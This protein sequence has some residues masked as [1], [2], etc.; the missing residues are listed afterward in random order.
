MSSLLSD[1]F[2]K[3]AKVILGE[4]GWR[5]AESDFKDK[6]IDS[7]DAPAGH[8]PFLA[9]PDTPET[10][11]KFITLCAQHKIAIVPQGGNTGRVHGGTPYG[12][13]LLSSDRLKTI[14]KLD[15]DNQSLIV[16]AGVSLQEVQEIADEAGL[17]FPLSLASEGTAQIGG[18]AATNAGGINV[19]QYGMMRDLVL[20]IE[21]V[22]PDGRIWDGLTTLRK[23]NTGYDLKQL[24][25]GS[26][27]TLGFI[28]AVSLKL[29]Q[30][31]K[32]L[33]SGY[34]PLPS[35][36]AALKLLNHLKASLGDSI[37]AFELMPQSGIELVLKYIPDTRDPLKT[38][39]AANYKW[40]ALFEIADFGPSEGEDIPAH[41]ETALGEALELGLIEDVILPK[42]EGE[43][44][45]LWQL[46]ETMPEAERRYGKAIKHDISVP[47]SK[48][49][50]F[51]ALAEE[52]LSK[53]SPDIEIIA[54]GHMGDGNLHYNVMPPD[55]M[56]SR[57]VT[58]CVH[59][60]VIELDGSIS[61]EHGIGLSKADELAARKSKVHM[62][63]V[64]AL[65]RAF[66]P[67]NRFNPGRLVT[68]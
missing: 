41:I 37:T 11:A 46:R 7:R 67:D 36:E 38:S 33:I 42:N 3:E 47:V 68:L 44:T 21:A 60:I 19:I 25:I 50:E 2:L 57:T 58:K 17:L 39:E 65:K 28:T 5:E 59:D 48:I 14:R 61:A 31:P 20:G 30:K 1:S 27:G 40:R 23:D 4:K 34:A 8:T 53:L 29:F 43:Q 45:T 13:V 54:F 15:K 66:D 63:M 56:D 52:A 24:F 26:E 18:V 22:L 16:E 64:R 55:G 51:M 12:E 62:D 9:L 35:P 6:L 10:A 49:P 32:K